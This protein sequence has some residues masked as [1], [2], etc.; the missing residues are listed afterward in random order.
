MFTTRI[1]KKNP[2]K[3][4]N[5]TKG[6]ANSVIVFERKT[7]MYGHIYNLE[8]VRLGTREDLTQKI[9]MIYTHIIEIEGPISFL[10]RTKST[11]TTSSVKRA[12]SNC[13]VCTA[14][15]NILFVSSK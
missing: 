5:V 2:K 13:N 14:A 6:N 11:T 10:V 12:F 15:C 3:M 1:K 4:L 7:P 8:T 9:H